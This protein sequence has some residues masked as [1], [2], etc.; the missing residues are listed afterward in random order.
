MFGHNRRKREKK[1]LKKAKEAF[2][3]EKSIYEQQQPERERASREETKKQVGVDVGEREKEREAAR[4]R[5]RTY[6]EEFTSRK[7]QGLS[8]DERREMQEEASQGIR[9]NLRNEQKRIHA[10]HGRKGA[11]RSGIAFAQRQEL[12]RAAQE[13]QGQ[14]QRDINR[15]D[16]DVALKRQ[17]QHFAIEQGE[18]GQS[19]LDR[20][21]A[22]DEVEMADERRRQ[23]AREN[24]YSNLFNSLR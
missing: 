17:A 20:Q 12:N 5:G 19:S 13:Q 11:G 16:R 7:F 21:L 22:Q 1:K 2:S 9:H 10:E 6:A 14:H 4:K 15:L 18:A 8:P 24:Q 23:R 3:Q